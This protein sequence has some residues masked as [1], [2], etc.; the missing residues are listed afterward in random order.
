[1]SMYRPDPYRLETVGLA[2]AGHAIV[3][4]ARVEDGRYRILRALGQ[5]AGAPASTAVSHS[6]ASNSN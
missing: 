6:R 4:A 1:M 3:T 2:R 5:P